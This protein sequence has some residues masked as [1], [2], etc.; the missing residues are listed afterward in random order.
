MAR[1]PITRRWQVVSR[2][3]A[4]SDVPTTE[5]QNWRAC[6]LLGAA[7]L[8]KTYELKV[9]SDAYAVAGMEVRKERLALLGASPEALAEKLRSVSRGATDRTVILLDALDEIM[10]PVKQAAIVVASW[11]KDELAA[12]RPTVRISC[13]SAVWPD[14][15][16]VAFQDVYGDAECSVASLQTLSANDIAAAVESEGIP[17]ADFVEALRAAGAAPLAELPLM[18]RMLVRIHRETGTLP[19]NRLQL[20]QRGL[21]ELAAERAERRD[22][23]TDGD[24]SPTVILEA[25]ERVACLS[26]LSGKESIDLS[27]TPSALSL[28]WKDLAALP[29]SPRLE[30]PLLRALGKSGVCESAGPGRFRFVHRQFAEYLAGRRIATLPLHQAKGLLASGAG[31][32]DGVAGPLRETAAFAAME[33]ASVAQWITECD[34]EVVGL[35]DV[36]DNPLRRRA[37]LNLLARFRSH[38]LTDRQLA[39]DG[40]EVQGV[41]YDDAEEDL[42]PVL[43]ER[44]EDALDVLACAVYLIEKWELA[45]MSEDLA[46]LTLDSTAP[47]GVRVKAGYALLQMGLPAARH[48]LKPL[49]G[50]SPEDVQLE[51][52]G[53][54]LRCCWPDAMTADELF[55]ALKPEGERHFAGAYEHFLYTLDEQ[56]FDAS[57]HRLA[58]LAW[59]RQYA[60]D[61]EFQ[62]GTRLAKHIARA[63]LKEVT[64][65]GIADALAELV[66]EAAKSHGDSPLSPLRRVRLDAGA[67]EEDSP[68]QSASE[69]IRRALIDAILRKTQDESDIFWV[70]HETPG[71][72]RLTDFP[73]LLSR[74]IDTSL[75]D[76]SRR[77]YA[78]LA[79]GLPW[80]GNG[81]CMEAWFAVREV[82]PVQSVLDYPLQIEIGSEA[83]AA[84]RKA[85][86]DRLK[87]ARPRRAPKLKPSPEERIR[88]MLE[89]TE[90]KDLNWFP[91][92]CQQLTLTETSTHYEFERSLTKTPGWIGADEPRRARICDVARR[93]LSAETKEPDR[94][95]E[96]PLNRIPSGY[97]Q[98]LLLLLDQDPD[99]LAALP[100]GWWERWSWY[101]LRELRPNMHGEPDEPKKRLLALLFAKAGESVRTALLTLAGQSEEDSRSLL[102]DLLRLLQEAPDATLDK[103]LLASIQRGEVRSD[104]VA[105]VARFLFARNADEA[106]RVCL[107]R[108]DPASAGEESAI[109]EAASLMLLAHGSDE[110]RDAVL[111]FLER[112]SDLAPRVLA[113]LAH[114]KWVWGDGEGTVVRTF[115]VPQAERLLHLLITHFP[116]ETDP[117]HEGGHFVTADDSARESR[118]RLITDLMQRKT[119]EAVA[120]MRRLEAKFEAKYAWLRRPRSEAERSLRLSMWSPIPIAAIAEVLDARAKRLIRSDQDALDGVVEAI[121]AYARSLRHSNPSP[122]EDLWN[123]PRGSALTPKEEER[124]SDKVCLAIADYFRTL[125]VTADREVQ[126][127]RRIASRALGGAPGSA[128]DV[129]VKVP[130]AGAVTGD[131]ICIPVEVKLAHNPEAK[132]GLCEQLVNRY[133]SETGAHGA[134]F[135]VAWMAAPKL[136]KRYKPQWNSIEEARAD[137]DAQAKTASK[138][139]RLDVRAQVVDASIPVAPSRAK[140]GARRSKVSAEGKNRQHTRSAKDAG[141]ASSRPR[142]SEK[143][144]SGGRPN[145]RRKKGR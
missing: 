129:F 117:K 74:A 114:D 57:G 3:E 23:R 84:A 90:T 78:R 64:A 61:R 77:G 55:A 16:R 141:K 139:E 9:L 51:L 71:L 122:L 21:L 67:K 60:G 47:L 120:V 145:R 25:G 79:R 24:T 80:L 33:N 37:T 83:A 50:G 7:G 8:G 11:A 115:V 88:D 87:W 68:L 95:R 130:A 125:A 131:A 38:A 100:V 110:A 22:I 134:V 48:R 29:G 109:A 118:D 112:R 82:E 54:A 58:G 86:A 31:W 94:I 41:K 127:S 20:F 4:R 2:T 123:N 105:A 104:R 19:P 73:W 12:A 138:D 40:M 143:R 59:A 144:R 72:V 142:N 96:E 13:R 111:G 63:A 103:R 133:V 102:S 6:C 124:V 70:V 76:A 101:I 126:L 30:E 97:M 116:P 26:L 5:L 98:A 65:P 46:T 56:G 27:D 128:V 44:G 66:I 136:A 107:D 43:L 10:V 17:L 32:R 1:W 34:P 140:G 85:H 18:L 42:R 35:S 75:D 93:Y 121:E 39:W 15:I 132:T 106:N 62:T 135:V 119:P 52:K 89:R 53:V 92:L 91:T 81:D 137:L 28:D 36:A 49:I 69:E 99:W 113:A 108:L 45:S 14:L